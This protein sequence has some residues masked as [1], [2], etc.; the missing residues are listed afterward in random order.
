[1]MPGALARTFRVVAPPGARLYADPHDRDSMGGTLPYGAVVQGAVSHAR[2][3]AGESR[4][5]RRLGRGDW[6]W[7]GALEEIQ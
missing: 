5:L 1:M 3:V 2:D 4:W 7:L 6:L